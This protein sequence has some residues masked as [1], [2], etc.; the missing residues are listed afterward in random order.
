MPLP[1]VLSYRYAGYPLL[2]QAISLPDD[3]G[4]NG[5]TVDHFLSPEVAPQLQVRLLLLRSFKSCELLYKSGESLVHGIDMM[6]V[7]AAGQQG[8]LQSFV[9]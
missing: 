3:S 8:D 7:R 5:T 2:L 4:A 6:R 9:C 1:A